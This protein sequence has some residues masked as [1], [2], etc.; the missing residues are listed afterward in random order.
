MAGKAPA[1]ATADPSPGLRGARAA[2]RSRRSCCC[3][4][5]P[6]PRLWLPGKRTS[7]EALVQGIRDVDTATATASPR[8]SPRAGASPACTRRRADALV[9]TV[10]IAPDGATRL[11]TVGGPR[12]RRV[13]S[14]VDLAPAAGWDEREAHDLYGVALR[15]PRAAAAARRRTTPDLGSWTVPVRGHDTY[16]VAVGPIHAGVIESGHFRFHVV[17]DRILHLDA[18]LFYKHR[19]LERAA[20]G[21]TLDRRRRLRRRAPA[22]RARSPT[23]SPTRRPARSVLGLEPTAELARARTILLE[24]ERTWSHLNDIAAVCAG[25]GLAAGNNLFAALTERARRLNA[26]L[27]GHR[28]LFG[29]VQ[30]GGSGLALDAARGAGRSR[31]AAS[32]RADSERGW[33]ELL[34]NFSFQDRLPDIGVVTAT[35]R[36]RSAPSA[37]RARA[38]GIADDARP[39]ARARLRRVRAGRPRPRRRRRARPARAARPRA[40]P[41]IR[42]CSTGC[43]TGRSPP[44]M[45]APDGRAADRRRPRREP[46]R[47]DQ[48]RRRAKRTTGRAAPPPHRLVR[49]L[50]G[51]RPRRGRQPA[52]RL[53]AH[54][55]ELRALLRLRRPLMLTLLRDLRRLRTTSTCRAPDRG[56]SLA[57]RHVDAGSCNGCEHELT[58]TIS[59]YYDLQRYGLG[60]VASPRHADVLLVTGTVTTRMREPLLDRLQRHARTPP[61][62]RARRLRTRPRRARHRRRASPARRGAPA[63]RPAH[64]RLPALP[65]QIA[66]ALLELIDQTNQAPA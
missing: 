50:A 20:E 63:R 30:V 17:G 25:V 64:P 24:L 16:Q 61:R 36:A 11:E 53:P 26:R 41:D 7:L 3:S 54:Q 18:R 6:P 27:T 8:R 48:L 4:R 42:R 62:R 21:A 1:A 39:T 56:R 47:R 51:R 59:P 58:L 35:R 14:I 34:F 19:G 44:P 28:F 46:A 65:D 60:I 52:A 10:L 38:A 12:R 40:A 2:D 22:P 29:T 55:Q 5:S 45:R 43:S 37:P 9:R 57:I 31:G 32:I 15:R 23:A 13:P 33:R 66:A 49:Q